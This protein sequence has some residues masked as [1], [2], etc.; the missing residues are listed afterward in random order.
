MRAAWRRS[1][2]CRHCT[3][4]HACSHS[5]CGFQPPL[6]CRAAALYAMSMLTTIPP[7]T[8]QCFWH[9]GHRC[10]AAD[11][12]ATHGVW[13]C[14]CRCVGAGH[15]CWVQANLFPLLPL[16]CMLRRCAHCYSLP[17]PHVPSLHLCHLGVREK[18]KE[19]VLELAAYL[20]PGPIQG[21]LLNQ[22]PEVRG[23]K[24]TQTA[25][26][27]HCQTSSSQRKASAS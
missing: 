24:S 14:Q 6:H 22:I 3:L 23:G 18:A 8:L 15:P 11:C 7:A 1:S 13:Q 12:Q 21:G 17:N 19:L 2:G 20:G 4:L 10:Q 16:L 9:Q 25:A 27:G 26:G 5:C